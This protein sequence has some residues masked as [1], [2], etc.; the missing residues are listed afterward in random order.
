M[1]SITQLLLENGADVMAQDQSGNT[2]LHLVFRTDIVGM[3]MAKGA[4]VN[5]R[6]AKGQ[7]PV[8]TMLGTI[9]RI[10]IKCFLPYVPNWNIQDSNGDTPLR[11]IFSKPYH[12]V[13]DLQDL[14]DAGADLGKR[15]KKGEAPIHVLKEISDYGY[16]GKNTF[17]DLVRAG[18]DLNVRDRDGRTVLLRLLAA[19]RVS[20]Q[21]KSVGYALDC[22]AQIKVVDFEGNG[23]LHLACDQPKDDSLV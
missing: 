3:L 7:T 12:P 8:D 9:S 20:Y 16:N 18:A 21:N 22:G 17:A 15:N 4:Y 10:D 5:K 6:N 11:I 1:L 13:E 23:P 14:V 2:P 19:H